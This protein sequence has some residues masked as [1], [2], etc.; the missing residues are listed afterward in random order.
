MALNSSERNQVKEAISYLNSLV[1]DASRIE[2]QRQ[3]QQRD[4]IAAAQK[5]RSSV[6]NVRGEDNEHWSVLPLTPNETKQLRPLAAYTQQPELG[7]NAKA[8]LSSILTELPWRLRSAKRNFGLRRLFRDAA[9]KAEAES[10]GRFLLSYREVVAAAGVHQILRELGNTVDS[11]PSVS[12]ED[13]L[14]PSVG[15]GKALSNL[16]PLTLWEAL[17]LRALPGATRS[18]SKS[19]DNQQRYEQSIRNEAARI[20]SS[21]AKERLAATPVEE[22]K[23]ATRQRISIAPLKK[24]GFDTV[25]KVLSSPGRVREAPGIGAKTYPRLV[26]A[27]R[28]VRD[29]IQANTPLRIDADAPTA[30]MGKLILALAI[31][32]RT[33]E[34]LNRPELDRILAELQPLLT[35]SVTSASYCV[36]AGSDAEILFE[37]AQRIIDWADEVDAK[38]SQAD[39]WQ[40]FLDRPAHYYA[41][42]DELGIVTADVQ[43]TEGELPEEVLEAIRRSQLDKSLLNVSLRGYQDFGARFALVQKKVIIGDEMGLGKTIEA[44]AVIAHLS[45]QQNTHTLVICPAA[46]VTNWVRETQDKSH[47]DVY[48]LHGDDRHHNFNLWQK[49]GGVA[50]TTF[51]MLEWVEPRLSAKGHLDVVVVDEAH[52]VKNPAALRSA[53]SEALINRARYAILMT[54]TPLENRVEEFRNLVTYVQPHLVVNADDLRPKQFRIDVAPAYLRRNQEDVLTE[55]PELVEVDEWLPLSPADRRA[56][57]EAVRAGQF[58]KMRQAPL[59]QGNASTKLMQIMALAEEAQENGRKVVVFSNYLKVLDAITQT[60]APSGHVFGPITGAVPAGRRQQIIDNFSNAPDGAVLVSQVQAG[61]VGLNIQ[62]ASVVVIAEPQVKPTTEW[63]AIARAYRMGQIKTVQVHR[64]LSEQSVDERMV[65]ILGQ[66]KRTFED[67]AAISEMAEQ[68]PE[69][70]DVSEVDLVRRVVEAEQKRLLESESNEDD[71]LEEAGYDE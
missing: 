16:G 61:G 37:K 38:L 10:S 32:E 29:E 14:L 44:L 50:I 33:R 5:L 71:A 42:L 11:A 20:T 12:P 6:I 48:R 46:V 17:T 21:S 57:E 39:A 56:Y 54:G 51:G 28:A 18:L 23:S 59:L 58:H 60:L 36:F 3:L 8:W 45:A 62:A 7:P 55:L 41:L 52:Y 19:S 35:S 30:S 65:E 26:D 47:L 4:G 53:R 1:S 25:D 15:L 2:S 69:A 27:A 31:W 40:D 63:Q 43:A 13:A 66:K 64:L 49:N 70:T 9:V 67:F 22:L 68:S 24:A 34:L